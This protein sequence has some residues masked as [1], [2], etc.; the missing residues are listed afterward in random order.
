MAQS[1]TVELG[2]IS[3]VASSIYRECHPGAN[4][5]NQIKWVADG[6]NGW[7]FVKLEPK[8]VKWWKMGKIVKMG[9]WVKWVKWVPILKWVNGENGENSENG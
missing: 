2:T 6:Y 7:E 8:W 4:G 9:K 1:P 3:G 5:A